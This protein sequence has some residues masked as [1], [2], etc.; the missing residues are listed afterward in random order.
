MWFFLWIITSLFADVEDHLRKMPGPSSCQTIEG[1]DFIYL[2]NLD[3]RPEKWEKSISQLAPY[4][5]RPCRFQA[6]NGW[7]LSLEEINDVGLRYCPG[8]RGDFL[9]TCYPLDKHF[10]PIHEYI[11]RYGKNYFCHCM[12]RG[13]IGIMLSHLSVLQDAFDAGHE[14]IWVMEDDIEVRKDPRILSKLI[15]NLDDLVGSSNWDVL[16]TDRD[17]RDVYGNYVPNFYA[18][19]RPDFVSENNYSLRQSIG[20][21]FMQIGARSGA[22]SMILRK[23]GIE[24]ILSFCKAHQIFF[25]YD[26]EYILPPGIR[27]FSVVEDVV[28]NLPGAS[29]DNGG[30]NYEVL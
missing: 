30:P 21:N 11:Q 12:S 14:T 6:V 27:L 2:I 23:S 18:G 15:Q 19:R 24:K 13:A 9:G 1:I 20:S 29:S 3:Q 4:G 22:H 5:I 25:P 16:F 26:M 10:E 28:S 17:I 8:M 7:K